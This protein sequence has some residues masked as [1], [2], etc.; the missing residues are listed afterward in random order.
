MLLFNHTLE[1]LVIVFFYMFVYNLSLLVFF[2]TLFQF[3][4]F[5]INTIN[6]LSDVKSNNFFLI[7][8]TF[9]FFSI[10]GIPPFLGFF[11][12]ILIL[13]VLLNS[14]F[15]LLFIF[16]FLFLF[17]ALYFY[18]QNLRFLYSTT[19]TKLNF[20]FIQTFALSNIFVFFTFNFLLILLFSFLF[21]DDILIFFFWLLS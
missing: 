8:F 16:Y 18:L 7:I 1:T 4:S 11:S 9:I 10:A 2:W 20:F 12:K 21:F 17:F 19:K 13:I 14:N 15:Y 3:N 5:K 6:S